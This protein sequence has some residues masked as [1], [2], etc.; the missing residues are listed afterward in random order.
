MPTKIIFIFAKNENENNYAFLAKKK[1]KLKSTEAWWFKVQSV[2]YRCSLVSLNTRCNVSYQLSSNHRP[3]P[4]TSHNLSV[5]FVCKKQK[6][7]QLFCI[8]A[9]YRQAVYSLQRANHTTTSYCINPERNIK[10]KCS[11]VK[12][13]WPKLTELV[14][15]DYKTKNVRHQA[16]DVSHKTFTL[17]HKLLFIWPTQA[18]YLQA[19]K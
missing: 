16:C 18:N 1:Q 10:R 17:T 5:Y 4:V 11:D 19:Q 14:I 12:W 8:P 9:S 7:Y 13:N 6:V 2:T 3:I 15:F